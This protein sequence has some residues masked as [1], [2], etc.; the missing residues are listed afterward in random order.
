M[1]NEGTCQWRQTSGIQRRFPHCNTPSAH[2]HC[3]FQTGHIQAT[4][5]RN[6]PRN[7]STYHLESRLRLRSHPTLCRLP[8][9]PGKHRSQLSHDVNHLNTSDPSDHRYLRS[10]SG[11]CLSHLTSLNSLFQTLKIRNHQ[12]HC[13]GPRPLQRSG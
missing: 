2:P 1:D 8:Y 4:S 7:Q 6:C 12:A 13:P 11:L 9:R 5:H 10:R 3:F